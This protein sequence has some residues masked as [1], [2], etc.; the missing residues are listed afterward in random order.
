MVDEAAIAELYR[1][2]GHSLFR[3]CR[4]LVGNEDDARELMQEAFFQFWKG[5]DRFEGRSAAFTYLYRIATNLSIDRLRRRRTA[6]VQVDVER[7]D[8]AG[9]GHQ[10]PEKQTLAAQELAE[11]TQGLDEE[12]ITVAVMSHVD[13][14]TQEEI[15][16]ALA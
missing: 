10:G 16:T 2:Y 15:A 5:R 11:L 1:R 13:G 14:L 12:T 9:K 8:T 4:Q 3:R 7:A 6:G